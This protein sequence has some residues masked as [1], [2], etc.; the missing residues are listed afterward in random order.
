ME[1]PKYTEYLHML[2]IY[3]KQGRREDAEFELQK[4]FEQGYSLGL[5]KGWAIEQDKENWD[6]RN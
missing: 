6:E 2:E 3:I 4:L 5:N 1:Y